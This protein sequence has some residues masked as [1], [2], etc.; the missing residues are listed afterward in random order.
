MTPS[1]I[2]SS[3][4][5]SIE[6]SEKTSTTDETAVSREKRAALKVLR[7]SY[8]GR[9][10][11]LLF[12]KSTHF[13]E[14]YPEDN[15]G[16]RYRGLACQQLGDLDLAATAYQQAVFLRDSD[17]ISHYCLGLI[18]KGKGELP[19]A[20]CSLFKAYQLHPSSAAIRKAHQEF[21]QDTTTHTSLKLFKA[22][23]KLDRKNVWA[24]ESLARYYL[25]K[26]RYGQALE[27]AKSLPYVPASLFELFS[28]SLGK[29]ARAKEKKERK[30]TAS[31]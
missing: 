13:I 6:G 24:G 15:V 21:Y 28:E 25:S 4:S 2:I 23:L 27:V 22:I 31:S 7:S 3:P 30:K 9:D 5:F 17:Y 14:S 12:S 26:D 29:S 10:W 19:L 8:E 18:Q 1:L 16:W 20:A 11:D